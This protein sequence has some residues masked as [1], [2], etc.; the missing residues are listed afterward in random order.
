MKAIFECSPD[1][2][3]SGLNHSVICNI[4]KNGASS[5]N[6]LETKKLDKRAVFVPLEIRVSA[7]ERLIR[8]HYL[9]VEELHC[10]DKTSKD[11]VRQ[12]VLDALFK[13]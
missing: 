7:L 1:E 12:A 2:V 8:E 4:T 9:V 5:L 13:P 3:F 6:E 10:R 11:V